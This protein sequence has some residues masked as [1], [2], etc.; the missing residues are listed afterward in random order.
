MGIYCNEGGRAING[1]RCMRC[2]QGGGACPCIGDGYFDYLHYDGSGHDTGWSCGASVSPPTDD[3][4]IHLRRIIKKTLNESQ[5][6]T[7]NV[8]CPIVNCNG[9]TACCNVRDGIPYDGCAKGET[10]DNKN[11]GNRGGLCVK[12]G[13]VRGGDYYDFKYGDEDLRNV[14]SMELN[15]SQVLLEKQCSVRYNRDQKKNG[16]NVYECGRGNTCGRAEYGWGMECQPIKSDGMVV[17]GSDDDCC[18]FWNDIGDFCVERDPACDE[19]RSYAYDKYRRQMNENYLTEKPG[20]RGWFDCP[21]CGR[22]GWVT[23]TKDGKEINTSDG[24]GECGCR[25]MTRGVRDLSR[26]YDVSDGPQAR[27]HGCEFAN[28]PQDCYDR[29]CNSPAGDAQ[30][31]CDEADSYA[32]ASDT[33]RLSENKLNR[34]VNRVI[35]GDSYLNEQS[36]PWCCVSSPAGCNC[37][38][39]STGGP[40]PNHPTG[41]PPYYSS[42]SRCQQN[43]QS[44]SSGGCGTP[45]PP[46]PTPTNPGLTPYAAYNEPSFTMAPKKAPKPDVSRL[47]ERMEGDVVYDVGREHVC[48]KGDCYDRKD[49]DVPC[50]GDGWGNGGKC[51]SSGRKC[52]KNC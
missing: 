36:S 49:T 43:C 8:P 51:F 45:P 15:E 39:S 23:C 19:V 37:V 18:L 35:N 13:M 46:P 10:C 47:R 52:R 24:G 7:E 12:D 31:C 3:E 9:C 25:D 29:C 11:H 2:A 42:Q 40:C 22:D 5:L 50:G 34:I 28:D 41:A 17:G 16:E 21:S 4:D 38:I 26:G 30:T 14:S 1:P 27:I 32:M 33:R 48:V 20:C 6:L 44:L